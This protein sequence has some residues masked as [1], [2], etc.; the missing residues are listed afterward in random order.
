LAGKYNAEVSKRLVYLKKLD[1]FPV[2]RMNVDDD[3]EEVTSTLD[4]KEIQVEKKDF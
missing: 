2:I 3:T 1:G 4:L